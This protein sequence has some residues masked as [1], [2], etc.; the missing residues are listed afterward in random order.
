MNEGR[1]SFTRLVLSNYRSVGADVSL[2]LGSLTALVGTNG[3]GKSNVA[4]AFRFLANALGDGLEGAIEARQ[5]F[6]GM[7]RVVPG[8]RSDVAMQF[9]MQHPDWLGEYGFVLTGN[10]RGDYR[11]ARE[12]AVIRARNGRSITRFETV[13]GEVREAP[14]G[15][16]RPARDRVN[17]TFPS[18]RPYLTKYGDN[19]SSVVRRVMGTDRG[20]QLRTALARVT[21]DVDNLR[22]RRGGG[23]YLVVEFAHRAFGD[24]P[25][26]FDAALESDGTLRVAGIIS[27]LLQTPPL[28][29]TGVEEPEL[30]VH[31]GM[32]PLLSDYLAE[33]AES[34]QVLLTTHSPELLDLI[35]VDDIRVVQRVGG[36]TSVSPVDEQQ[37]RLVRENLT[38]PGE[39]LRSEG[40]LGPSEDE[41]ESEGGR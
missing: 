2:E 16:E 27:A 4:D 22:V 20:V 39:L 10:Q 26:W 13:D 1:A 28:T 41:D 25:R 23:G 9:E 14:E 12:R 15:L 34:T 7:R 19:W 11:V 33:A 31:A 3:S 32:V 35:P 8:R 37:R 5:G 24:R 30:T 29:L 38:T 18:Q 36:A 6:D 21:G 17:L 40:L